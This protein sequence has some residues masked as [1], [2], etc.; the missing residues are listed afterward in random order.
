MCDLGSCRRQREETVTANQLVVC[1]A[2]IKPMPSR[3]DVKWLG[4]DHERRRFTR[5]GP[6]SARSGHPNVP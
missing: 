1:A 6:T 2:L 3:A 5:S 4:L